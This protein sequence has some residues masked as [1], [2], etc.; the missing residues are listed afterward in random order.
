[1]IVPTFEECSRIIDE[2]KFIGCG[3]SRTVY[4]HP[5][6]PG[7]VVKTT[8]SYDRLSLADQNLAEV[9]NYKWLMARGLPDNV[10]VPKTVAVGGFVVQEYVQGAQPVSHRYD[11]L[12]NSWPCCCPANGL[13]FC[14]QE[15]AYS[16]SPD[17]HDENV[18]LVGSTLWVFDLGHV[19]AGA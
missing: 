5:D 15:V 18:V 9:Q 16:V 8:G 7:I 13:D 14:W 6:F 12:T 17:A 2:G 10:R 19:N 1:M 3:I 11:R 4:M